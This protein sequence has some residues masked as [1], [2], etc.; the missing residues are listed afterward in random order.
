VQVRPRRAARA[1]A[2]VI[3]MVATAALGIFSIAVSALAAA[4]AMV[5]VRVLTPDEAYRAVDWRVVFLLAGM[6][7][8]G[9]AVESTGGAALLA[10][11][12]GDL[13][14]RWG[15][16]LTV[17]LVYVVASL[18]TEVMSNNATAVLL[19]PVA[20]AVAAALGLDPEPLLVAVM[21]ATSASFMTPVGYQTNTMV[22]TAGGYRFTDFTRV[23][24]PL[25]LLM[26]AVTVVM[27]PW[28]WGT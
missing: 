16:T 3:A 14:S 11:L 21:L 18:L 9:T 19:A 23:G 6:L 15:L 7:A 27:V 13:G 8:L 2:I 10:G 20:I 25:N 5:I 22:F 17:G 24:A 26:L 1:V 4:V 12:V 28:I